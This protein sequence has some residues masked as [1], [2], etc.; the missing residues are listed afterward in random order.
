MKN[1]PVISSQDRTEIRKLG[2]LIE[3]AGSKPTLARWEV[4]G[5]T[6][7]WEKGSRMLIIRERTTT[8]TLPLDDATKTAAKKAVFNEVRSS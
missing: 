6:Y 2:D 3:V 5:I 7:E 8:H 4:S 1:R